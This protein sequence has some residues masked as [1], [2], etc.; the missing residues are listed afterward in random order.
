MSANEN[1]NHVS[2]L[3]L[4]CLSIQHSFPKTVININDFTLNYFD[5]IDKNPRSKIDMKMSI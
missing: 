2:V 3:H 4:Q 5:V 1:N